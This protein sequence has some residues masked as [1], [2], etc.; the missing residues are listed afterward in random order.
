MTL[1]LLTFAWIKSRSLQSSK[2]G[3][4]YIR[5]SCTSI[6]PSVGPS[7]YL[8]LGLLVAPSIGLSVALSVSLSVGPPVTFSVKSQSEHPSSSNTHFPH[9]GLRLWNRRIQF[10]DINRFPMSLGVSEGASERT[11][12]RSGERERSEQCGASEWVSGTSERANGGASG[13]VLHASII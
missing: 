5:G 6:P 1:Y 4:Y 8:S 9:S 11:N 10:K 2:A 3:T 7:N 12:E 13:P